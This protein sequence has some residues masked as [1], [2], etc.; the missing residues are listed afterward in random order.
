MCPAVRLFGLLRLAQ[1]TYMFLLAGP[2]LLYESYDTELYAQEDLLRLEQQS[3]RSKRWLGAHSASSAN[4]PS[5]VKCYR[6][7]L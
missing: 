4:I 2:T 7:A 6:T 5:T 3:V 1:I